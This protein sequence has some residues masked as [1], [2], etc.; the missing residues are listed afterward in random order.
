MLRAMPGMHF[1]GAPLWLW[2]AF[3]GLVLAL[4]LADFFLTRDAKPRHTVE[5]RSYWL[6]GC[7]IAAALLFAF[8]VARALSPA[9]GVAYL[10]GYGIEEALSLDNLFVFV[11]LFRLFHLD[12]ADQRKVLF[13]GVLGAIL[14][15]GAMIFAGLALLDRFWWMNFIFGAIL[16]LTAWHLLRESR[17][18][19][20]GQ[21]PRAIR[22]LVRRLARHPE[23]GDQRRA[24]VLRLLPAILAIEA[25]DALFATDSVP[26]V[27]AVTHHPFVAYSSNILAVLSLRSLYFTVAAAL[28]RLTRLHYGL[29]AILAFI[30]GKMMLTRFWEP[31]VWI[32]LAV[33][34]G[35]LGV[36]AAWS[37]LAPVPPGNR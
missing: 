2:V 3:H 16:L 17:E 10:T 12:G 1:A 4:L 31:P 20:G 15:R 25:T 32:S 18:S 11:V 13:Y 33:V 9:D 30:G 21:P 24:A 36:S 35:C 14:L 19:A 7:W 28:A 27:L 8:A 34:A 26:A 23:D 29:A 37:L 6:T 5:Q 22:W